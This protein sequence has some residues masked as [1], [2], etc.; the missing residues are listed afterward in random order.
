MNK[1]ISKF[2]ILSF[3]KLDISLKNQKDGKDLTIRKITKP[4]LRKSLD[5][6]GITRS[7]ADTFRSLINA[8]P[9]SFF[10]FFEKIPNP[11]SY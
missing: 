7:N 11:H 3:A 9:G 8:P 5:D 10:F 4:V 1:L 2:V 6:G